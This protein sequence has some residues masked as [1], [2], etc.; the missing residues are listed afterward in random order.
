M[1]NYLIS[2]ACI[3]TL[4]IFGQTP[5]ADF[6]G[7]KWDAPYILNIPN[8]WGIE[9]FL[10]PISFAPEIKYTGVEDI[11]FSPGWGKSK[12]DEYWTYAFLWYLEG[13]IKTNAGILE[14]NL[15]AYYS[16]LVR[17]NL[18]PG[19]ITAE[20]LITVNTEIKKVKTNTGDLKT[21]RGTIYMLDYMEQKPITLN[22]IIHI[23]SCYG[24]NKTFIF[25]EISPKPYSAKVWQ[26]LNQLW[27]EF[28]CGKAVDTK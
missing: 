1:K 23:K 20:K 24:Q 26:R 13:G 19:K 15:K 14:Q 12:S 2:L 27:A 4:T 21:Y 8:G 10:L 17:S 11:R 22:C 9:R 3:T 28:R 18:E 7:K 5:K 6:D 16:G 25:Y